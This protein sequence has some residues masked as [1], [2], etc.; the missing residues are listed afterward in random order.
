MTIFNIHS[1]Q[2]APAD[3]QPF[4]AG[5]QKKFG[6]VPNLLGGLAEAPATL[7]AYL[8]LGSIL[9][10]ASL[11]P[12]ERQVVLPATSVENNCTAWSK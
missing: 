8:A 5:A 2:Q 10:K 4:L 12:V 9:D 1:A 6:F 3:A 11:N 7:E